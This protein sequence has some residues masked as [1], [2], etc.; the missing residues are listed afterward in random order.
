MRRRNW[1]VILTGFVLIVFTIGFYFF[2]LMAASQSTDPVAL[3]QTVGAVS[4]VVIGISVAMIIV[5]LIG[6]KV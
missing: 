5:G 2:M 6:K 1:R 4:G 3:M